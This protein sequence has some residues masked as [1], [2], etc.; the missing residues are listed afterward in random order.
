MVMKRYPNGAEGKRL[1]HETCA[2]A[3]TAWIETC[4]I[5]HASGSGIDY[6]MVTWEELACGARLEEFDIANM[7][8]RVAA[9]CDLWAPT[10]EPRGRIVLTGLLQA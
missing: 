4:A 3:P 1:F 5:E 8:A 2:G 10:L 6:P 9:L 7:P